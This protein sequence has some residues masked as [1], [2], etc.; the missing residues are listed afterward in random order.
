MQKKAASIGIIGIPDKETVSEL[1]KLWG[2]RIIIIEK[3]NK[4]VLLV[5]SGLFKKRMVFPANR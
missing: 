2:K 1:E 4:T 5:G 3:K